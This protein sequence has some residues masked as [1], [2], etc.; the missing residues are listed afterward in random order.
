MRV[1]DKY[2]LELHWKSISY[3]TEDVAVL[4]GAYFSGPALEDAE[5]LQDEDNLT[6]DMTEQ[7]LVFPPMA[8]FYQAVLNWKG[9]QYERDKIFLKE[10]Y[11]KGKYINSIETLE[12]KD[13]ITIDCTAHDTKKMMGKRGKRVARGIYATKYD[14][15][16]VYWAEVM[17][18]ED[19]KKY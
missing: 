10:A 13:W 9:V 12:N 18:T 4:K 8:D 16:L 2:R 19:G 5:P 17:W 7:H 11:I 1:L 6:L 14:H 15:A 3:Q